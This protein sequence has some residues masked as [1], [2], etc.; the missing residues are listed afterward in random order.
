VVAGLLVALV[1][2]GAATVVAAGRR[3]ARHL[4]QIAA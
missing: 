4:Q 3:D 2:A 1:A